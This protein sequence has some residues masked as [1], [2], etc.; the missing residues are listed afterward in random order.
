MQNVIFLTFEAATDI[1]MM[2]QMSVFKIHDVIP[3]LHP[4][5]TL[6]KKKECLP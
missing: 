2:R 6:K 4:Q 5:L 1:Q 3:N